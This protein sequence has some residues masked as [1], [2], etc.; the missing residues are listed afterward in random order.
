MEMA[1]NSTDE[2]EQLVA[3]NCTISSFNVGSH[4]KRLLRRRYC[5]TVPVLNR[6]LGLEPHIHGGDTLTVST[7]QYKTTKTKWRRHLLQPSFPH[8]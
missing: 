7:A 6:V 4:V 5:T 2:M 8:A 3:D 1:I